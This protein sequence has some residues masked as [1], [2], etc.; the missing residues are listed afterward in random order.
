MPQFKIGNR[1]V[2]DGAP[3]YIIAEIGS[4]FDGDLERVKLLAR[5]AKEDGADAFK[6]QNFKAEKIVS[7]I[8]FR[9]LKQGFQA[10]WD[11]P[12]VEVYRAAEFPREWLPEIAAYCKK[13]GID[14]FS[15]PYD[16]EAVDL[17]EKIN[18]PCHKIG[19]GEITNPKFLEYV[20]KTGKPIILA[21]GSADLHI[22][23]MAVNTIRKAGNNQIALLQCTTNYPSS[24]KH[25]NIRV[26][27]T[28]ANTF[29]CVVGVSDHTIGPTGGGDDP[30]DGLTVPL[31]AMGLGC[32]IIEKH[33]TDDPK[34]KGPDHPFAMTFSKSFRALIQGVRAAET[35]L[36]S[37]EKFITEDEK[38]TTPL[39][40][41]GLYAATD[42][43]KGETITEDKLMALRPALGVKPY[44]EKYIIG[45]KAGKD[46]PKGHPIHFD[47]IAGKNAS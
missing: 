26:M 21:T 13:I 32:K 12:V 40:T 16:T 37:A 19:S 47:D 36:G 34:R 25:S 18:V 45:Q 2:G 29:D 8:G 7:D 30:L 44:E 42:I 28:Y 33:I 46:I 14:F 43:K 22:V 24:I 9:N 17:L 3:C 20:A 31:T 4:N 10:K 35:A 1:V 23:Q 41:R 6:I 39:Q 27:Q 5:L 15:A 38:V 11:K